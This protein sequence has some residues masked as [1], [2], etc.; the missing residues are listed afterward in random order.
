MIWFEVL[1]D[2]F[3]NISA[4]W[5]GVVFIEPQLG[6]VN[7]KVDIFWLLFKILSGIISLFIAKYFKEK[8]RIK[9]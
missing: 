6:L 3:V 5:F 8:A 2:L 9:Q 4:G 7:T 1:S